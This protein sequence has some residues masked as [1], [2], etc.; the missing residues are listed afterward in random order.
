M[1]AA[2]RDAI[3]ATFKTASASDRE[4]IAAR[5]HRCRRKSE[6]IASDPIRELLAAN[7]ALREDFASFIRIVF[8]TLNPEVPLGSAHVEGRSADGQL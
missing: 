6:M 7:A 4:V 3:F 5:G 8:L 2:R 1:L